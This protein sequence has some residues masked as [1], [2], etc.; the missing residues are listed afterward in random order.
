MRN[1]TFYHMV[2]VKGNDGIE[3]MIS[4]KL[5]KSG[6]IA[7]VDGDIGSLPLRE[8]LP[9]LMV[10]AQCLA[11]GHKVL[12][13]EWTGTIKRTSAPDKADDTK[14]RW[15]VKITA[16]HPVAGQMTVTGN[17]SDCSEATRNFWTRWSEKVAG[18][19]AHTHLAHPGYV[20]A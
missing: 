18:T 6:K 3:S 17:G 4:I 12:P 15:T 1:T 5:D 19:G 9:W 2:L 10:R 11:K 13:N 14:S 8:G 16:K 20:D 7:K